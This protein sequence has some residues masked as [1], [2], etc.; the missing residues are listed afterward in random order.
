MTA[1]NSGSFIHGRALYTATFEE[2]ERRS[3]DGFTVSKLSMGLL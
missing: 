1:T 2:L 3:A